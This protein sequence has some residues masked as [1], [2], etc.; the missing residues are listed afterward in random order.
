MALPNEVLEEIFR[1][2]VRI[3]PPML[4]H[5]CKRTHRGWLAALWVCQR[6]RVIINRDRECWALSYTHIPHRMTFALNQARDLALVYTLSPYTPHFS[7]P[8]ILN[9]FYDFRR[10]D[11]IRRRASFEQCGSIILDRRGDV[12]ENVTQ[13]IRVSGMT[14][15]RKLD[16]L[17][18]R[19]Q[20]TSDLHAIRI[21]R[22]DHERH[23]HIEIL[24]IVRNFAQG[25][26]MPSLNAPALSRIKLHNCVFPFQS[27]VLKNISVTFTDLLL[28]RPSPQ[29]LLENLLAPH[30]VTL[31]N[32]TLIDAMDDLQDPAIRLD[33]TTVTFPQLQHLI[34]HG[35][36]QSIE[37]LLASVRYPNTTTVD[38]VLGGLYH[39]KLISGAANIVGSLGTS[40]LFRDWIKL[41]L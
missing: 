1:W 34:L 38:I 14:H 22:Y 5:D 13:L 12:L 6:W 11:Q 32:L 15:L 8:P 36:P 25:R 7:A 33:R 39:P 20:F 35:T 19:V 10:I 31:T 28:S 40:V 9:T 27:N 23:L 41:T 4:A 37:A 18:V 17:F 2:L 3:A 21:C 24:I 30:S 16:D 26:D 29:R